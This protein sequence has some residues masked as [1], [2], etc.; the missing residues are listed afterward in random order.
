MSYITMEKAKDMIA[1]YKEQREG[2]LQDTYDS[3]TLPL[4]ITFPRAEFDELLAQQSC[5]QVRIFLGMDNNDLIHPIIVAVDG[6]GEDILPNQD[7]IIIDNGTRCPSI[8]PPPS[9][10]N[11]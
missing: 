1:R 5:E 10:I 9:T 8:C 7:Y 11:P 4:N 3:S 2:M 6:Q